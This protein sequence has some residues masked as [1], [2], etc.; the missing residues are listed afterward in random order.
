M[1]ILLFILIMVI[2]V[3]IGLVIILYINTNSQIRFNHMILDNVHLLKD[4][5]LNLVNYAE[6]T[7]GA[8]EQIMKDIENIYD[9]LRE[10][11]K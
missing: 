8:I 6:V 9:K 10:I 11:D 5:L 4:N 3:L 1:G 7:D 2:L